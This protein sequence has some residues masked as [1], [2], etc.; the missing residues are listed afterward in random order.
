M[1][2]YLFKNLTWRDGK[3]NSTGDIRVSN[4]LI[5]EVGDNLVPKKDDHIEDFTN[6]FLYPGLVNGHDHLEMNLY[7]RMGNPPY[8]NYVEWSTSIYKPRESP[9]REIEKINIED[10]LLWG[11]IKNLISGVTTVVHHNPWHS[12]FL[13]G[14]F[15]VTVLRKMTWAHSL[16]FEQEIEK[17]F[18]ENT[19]V[20]FV[21]HAGEGVDE[22]SFAEIRKLDHLGLLQSNTVLVHA[23]ALNEKYL[24]KVQSA[25]ASIVWCPAS[26]IFMFDTTAPI[27]KMGDNIK[28]ALGTDSTLTGSTTLL[29]EMKF[30]SSTNLVSSEKIYEMVTTNSDAIFQI[31][32]SQI[33]F[34]F[35]ANFFICPI[36][37]ENYYDNLI[38]ITLA[39][40][41][42]VLCRGKLR[43][44]HKEIMM[45]KS[46]LKHDCTVQGRS[47]KIYFD[48]SALKR[49]IEK[50][51]G[52]KTLEQ[53]AIW[54]LLQM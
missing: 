9:I 17:K 44:A 12:V 23:I 49:K 38:N 2:S 10:R 21:V 34:S 51:I 8:N 35:E 30:A 14:D 26:N 25:K 36:K 54:R 46:L 29:D 33:R 13:K 7:P 16:S 42:V 50:K 3:Q 19:S 24:S 41:A 53:N 6:H 39:D 5:A 15:P 27:E 31:A 1:P 20:P 4:G 22:F 18:R 45:G 48:I 52:I 32:T 37:D 40:I 47:K 43:L 28:I 11:A